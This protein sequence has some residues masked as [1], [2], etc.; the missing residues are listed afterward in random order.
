MA[1]T[2][3]YG[4]ETMHYTLLLMMHQHACGPRQDK[5]KASSAAN[6]TLHAQLGICSSPL[7][8]NMFTGI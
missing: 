7:N 6:L 2:L 3:K 4:H 5:T 1:L 8:E